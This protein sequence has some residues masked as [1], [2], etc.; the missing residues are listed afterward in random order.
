MIFR[1]RPARGSRGAAV[2]VLAMLLVAVMLAGPARAATLTVTNTNDAGDGSLRQQIAGAAPGDTIVFSVTGPIVLTGGQLVVNK[3]LTIAGPGAK[4]L[5]VSGNN[6]SRVF[7]VASG[8]QIEI[9]GLTI[10][11]GRVVGSAGLS[12]VNGSTGTNGGTNGQ[13]GGDAGG[14]GVLNNG[15]L[16]LRDVSVSANTATGGAGGAGGRGGRWSQQYVRFQ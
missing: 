16:T 14:G 7:E 9:S 13:N 2:A 11:G 10:T 5:T 15:T 8:A 12:G 4:N 6:Q 1:P 3:D